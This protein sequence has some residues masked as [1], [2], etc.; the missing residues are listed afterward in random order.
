MIFLLYTTIFVVI[1]FLN[2]QS[3]VAQNVSQYTN[4]ARDEIVIEYAMELAS[5]N[6][7]TK[8]FTIS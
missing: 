4:L 8:L 1:L 3:Q 5:E 2:I 6:N 7:E